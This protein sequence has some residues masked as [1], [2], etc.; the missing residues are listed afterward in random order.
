MT[1]FA[2][3]SVNK[4]VSAFEACEQFRHFFK[5]CREHVVRVPQAIHTAVFAPSGAGK[6]VSCIIPFLRT[7]RDSC[8]VVDFKGE[9]ARLTADFRR[10]VLGHRV[11]ILDPFK[12]VT[13]TPDTFNP[14]DGIRAGDLHAIDECNDMAKALVIRSPE[15]KEPH[16][17][18]CAEFWIAAMLVLV[19]V[20]GDGQ[21]TRSLQTM[22]ELLSSPERIALAIKA[23]KES[24]ACNGM[25]ARMG[26]QLELFVD[27]ERSSVLSTVLRH[28]RFLDTPTV[29]ANTRTS[30]FDPAELG[31]GK[32]T[33]YLVLPP[34]HMRASAGLLRT[35]ISSFLRAVIKRGLDLKHPVH[36]V[37]DEA[38]SLGHLEVIEDA[39]DKYRGYGCRL[40]F[41]FQSLG[42]L[43]KTFPNGQ[44]QTL[45]SNTTQIYFAVNDTATADLVSA[46]L[47]EETIIVQSGG[48]SS[49]FS[50]QHSNGGH[51]QES[52]SYTENSN[53]NWS[54]NARRLLKPEEVIALPPRLPSPSHRACLPS[55][56]N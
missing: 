51:S 4:H 49:G 14:I 29:D 26:G 48:T 3:R 1:F 47:G 18:D 50:S 16:F 45:L 34:E 11:V 7:C 53:S 15:E 35:W 19:V 6:G 17:S 55:V 52:R 37:L 21:G 36:F 46:R 22:R 54:Q 5:R 33:I 43:R 25:L 39:V 20:Y 28:L 32:M 24:D 31:S 8:V 12:V 10:D 27:R 41:Y 30:S 13:S 38:A 23:M 9:N 2:Q 42:Q 44:D 40:Q 56:R